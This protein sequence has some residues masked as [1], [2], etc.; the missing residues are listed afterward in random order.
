[1][2]SL[3][4]IFGIACGLLLTLTFFL[5]WVSSGPLL[6]G[7]SGLNFAFGPL[8]VGFNLDNWL[9]IYPCLGFVVLTGTWFSRL[10]YDRVPIAYSIILFVCA[11]VGILFIY[12]RFAALM[13]QLSLSLPFFEGVRILFQGFEMPGGLVMRAGIG[14]YLLVLGLLCGILGGLFSLADSVQPVDSNIDSDSTI[15]DVGQKVDVPESM[16][17]DSGKHHVPKGPFPEPP[18]SK[19]PLNSPSD[20][21][22]DLPEGKLNSQST[23]DLAPKTI[24]DSIPPESEPA[25]KPTSFAW[26]VSVEGDSLPVGSAF[27]ISTTKTTIGRTAENMLTLND[28]AVSSRHAEI[29]RQA[30]KFLLFDLDS[31]N[32]TF[33]Y[34]DSLEDWE[35]INQHELKDGDRLKFG[36]SIFSFVHV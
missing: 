15:L 32:G 23:S 29:I 12:L 34:I 9:L 3:K 8:P 6:D 31:R 13:D 14:I 5:P 22:V 24:V 26:L 19:Q 21:L 7:L 4:N 17:I 36:R 20:T 18:A 10:T 35:P 25:Q 27:T 30:G 16:A 2:N 1:M 28:S 11:F 33:L